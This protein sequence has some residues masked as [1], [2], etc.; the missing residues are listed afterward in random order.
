[1]A[2]QGDMICAGALPEQL[3]PL[4][5]VTLKSTLTEPAVIMKEPDPLEAFVLALHERVVELE[6]FATATEKRMPELPPSGFDIRHSERG[7]IFGV[8]IWEEGWPQ[9]QEGFCKLGEQLLGE[10]SAK[11][12][13]L[14]GWTTLSLCAHDMLEARRANIGLCLAFQQ[15]FDNIQPGVDHMTSPRQEDNTS[16]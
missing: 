2:D 8:T 14:K 5:P 1:M 11:V 3:Q 4:Q 12:A 15:A 9:G 13:S 10:I 6:T 7:W 16:T